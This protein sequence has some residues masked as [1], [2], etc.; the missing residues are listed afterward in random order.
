MGGWR[1]RAPGPEPCSLGQEVMPPRKRAYNTGDRSPLPGQR[2]HSPRSG[3][4]M[5]GC[6]VFRT[7]QRVRAG[8]GAPG[9]GREGESAPDLGSSPFRTLLSLVRTGRCPVPTACPPPTP[10]LCSP[11]AREGCWET[12]EPETGRDRDAERHRDRYKGEKFSQKRVLKPIVS[13]ASPG[14]CGNHERMGSQAGGPALGDLR[15]GL[16]LHTA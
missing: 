4:G 7:C 11:G 12:R 15:A 1:E 2:L 14:R 3:T 9:A 6:L 5:R 16:P 8:V 13:P 10:Q